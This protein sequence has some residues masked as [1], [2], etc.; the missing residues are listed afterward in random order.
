V[1]A[2]LGLLTAVLGVASAAPPAFASASASAHPAVKP[3]ACPAALPG[4]HRYAPG[5]GHTVALTFDDGPGRDT[6]RILAILRRYRVAATFFNLGENEADHRHFVRMEH[7][8]G[9]PIGDHTWDHADLTTLSASGQASEMDRERARQRALTGGEPC[10]F[11][12]PYGSF[13]ATTLSLAR[14][15]R[16][17]VWNWSVDTEDWKAQG[18]GDAYWVHRITSRAEAGDT[19]RHPVILMHNQPAGNPATVAAL[20]AIIRHYQRLHYRFVVL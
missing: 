5:R 9:Y 18:S 17:T 2:A 19:Q 12:P 16:M 1:F 8:L 10:L 13:D 20:P 4:V 3:A 11:R 15:R 14:Q 6:G 7:D